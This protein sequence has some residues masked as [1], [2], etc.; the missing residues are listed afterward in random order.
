M[1]TCK[2]CIQCV[3]ISRLLFCSCSNHVESYSKTILVCFAYSIDVLI[4][5]PKL[6]FWGHT[7]LRP[8]A[9]HFQH[10]QNFT[11]LRYEF[12]W[13]SELKR[14]KQLKLQAENQCVFISTLLFCSCSNHVESYSKTILVC[15]A[16]SIDVL[17][18]HPKLRFW[19]HTPLRPN[20]KHFQ[21]SQ[22]FTTLRYEFMWL[23]EL[24]RQKQLKLQ[25]EN[26]CVFISTLLLYSCS[27]HVESY[28][29]TI[30]TGIE[31][32]CH[33]ACKPL[34]QGNATRVLTWCTS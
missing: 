4:L 12:M 3:F 9:K 15:F 11:T 18:L 6:R 10:S 31:N 34:W 23:S 14:Q 33:V 20:A 16:Y 19:G 30:L 8:N 26:Q 5:H 28:S 17:I 29:K 27:N 24:K 32:Y 21:H 25:A 22:N 13:L 7:P 2:A 1:N